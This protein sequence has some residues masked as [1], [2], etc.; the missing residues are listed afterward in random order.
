MNGVLFLLILTI[1]ALGVT[2][3]VEE[4]AERIEEG[5]E[6][7]ALVKESKRREDRRQGRNPARFACCGWYPPPLSRKERRAIRR[8]GKS[9]H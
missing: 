2:W 1:G 6:I 4:N 8:A 7:A 5:R 3:Y 9:R